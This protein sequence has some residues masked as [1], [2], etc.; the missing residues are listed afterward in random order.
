MRLYKME[1]TSVP[2]ESLGAPY[3]DEDGMQT[4]DWDPNWKPEGWKEYIDAHADEGFQWAR[5]AK[6]ES[7]RFFWPSEKRTYLTKQAAESKAWAVR[8]W[9]GKAIVLEA[10]VGEFIEVGTAARNR[11]EIKDLEKARK[12]RE[13][14]EKLV[15]DAKELEES[16]CLRP[17]V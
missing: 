12:L 6:A 16:Y 7:Y 1:I 14:A 9:G 10:E 15:K 3:T 5:D 11:Q 4:R 13:K 2:E 8:K 17:V